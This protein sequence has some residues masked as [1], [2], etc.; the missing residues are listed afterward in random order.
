MSFVWVGPD[1]VEISL[2]VDSDTQLLVGAMGLDSAPAT[3]VTEDR[4]SGDGAIVTQVRYPAREVV[5][6]LYLRDGEDSEALLTSMLSTSGGMSL[7]SI[8]ETTNG[9]ELTQV[10]YVGGLEG[11]ITRDNR[12][13]DWRKEVVQ[14]RALDPFWYG[15]QEVLILPTEAETQYNANVDYNAWLPYDGGGQFQ[16]TVVGDAPAVGEFV[17]QNM[18][19][20]TFGTRIRGVERTWTMAR[21]QNPGET[22]IVD[23]RY[24]ILFERE[25][26]P[27]DGSGEVDWR[28]LL[29]GSQLSDI[30]GGT[31]TVIIGATPG[32]SPS[33]QFRYRSRW[34]RPT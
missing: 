33:A 26:G 34:L 2:G 6:P 17:L 28:L 4:V 14:M 29:A 20:F 23:T 27:H 12:G 15:E 9:R 13:R 30:S 24:P 1:G 22:L 5:L 21:P 16:V 11:E 10:M 3:S 18:E 32:L 31:S 25:R 7:G 19:R 8:V